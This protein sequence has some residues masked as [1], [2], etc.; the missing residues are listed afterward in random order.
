MNIIIYIYI[1]KYKINNIDHTLDIF[2]SCNNWM[3]KGSVVTV[4]VPTFEVGV[5]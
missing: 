5:G 1:N 4:G 2:N 3:T